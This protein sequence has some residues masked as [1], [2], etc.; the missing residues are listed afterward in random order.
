MRNKI[1]WLLGLILLLSASLR[2]PGLNVVPPEL[3]GDEVDVGYQA[4]SLLKTGRDIYQNP[5]PTLV[6]SLAEWRLPLIVYQTVPTIAVFGNTEW[7]VRL[8][9][10]IFGSLAPIILFLLLYQ[11]TR[12]KL[13]SFLSAGVLVFMPWHIMYSRMAAFGVVTLIDLLLLGTLLYLKRRYVASSIFMALSIY[14]YGTATIFLPLLLIC[15]F[16][17]YRHKPSWVSGVVFIVLLVPFG[18]NLVSGQGGERFSVLSFGRDTETLENILELRQMSDPSLGKVFNNRPAAY[19]NLFT[20]NYLKSFS[21]EFLF[22]RGD[23]VVRHSLQVIGQTLPFL[24]PFMLIGFILLVVHRQWLWLIWLI[25]APIPAALTAD[26]GFHATRLFLLS[27]PLAVSTAYGLSWVFS[28]IRSPARGLIIVGFTLLF[29]FHFAGVAQYYLEV[30]PIRSRAWWQVGYKQTMAEVSRYSPEY[31]RVLINNTYEPSL[32]RFLFWTS[33][34]PAKFH[35][36]FTLDQEVTGIVTNYNGFTLD[37]KYF[38]GAFSKESSGS[39][40]TRMLPGSLY[41][42]SQRDD[43]P[44]GWDWRTTPPDR[45]RVLSTIT[46]YANQPLF[47]LVTRQ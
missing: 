32:I 3:F 22:T 36:N 35:T 13:T 8:P 25:A 43:I 31:S 4:F 26:G 41:V 29:I 28:K 10:A 44:G 37:G 18:L 14:T 24:A 17:I 27:I 42:I 23:P 15:L 2:L 20:Y 21:T 19:L 7:G 12:S 30:Y 38:F 40:T 5:V 6:H 34:P 16:L 11:L 45:V 47:Y 33:Y 46:D 9:E 1:V 39:F